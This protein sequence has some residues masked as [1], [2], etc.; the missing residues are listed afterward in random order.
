MREA[1][2]ER[3][4]RT[5]ETAQRAG[6]QEAWATTARARD[7]E[8]TVR[9]GTLEEVADSTS[10]SLSLRLF[11]D[12]R[13]STH[14]TTDL[15]PKRLAGF[16]EEA[17]AMTR[18]LQPDEFRCMP[19][20]E[21]FARGM[22]DLDLCDAAIPALDRGQRMAWC[23]AMNERCHGEPQVISVS[24]ATAD[25]HYTVAAAS[26]N[27]FRGS[28]EATSLS[29]YTEITLEEGQR[30]P[31]EVHWASARHAADLPDAAGIADEAM[32]LARARLG[33][34]KGATQRTTLVAANRCAG[35]LVGRLL[36]PAS[37]GTVQQERSFWRDRLD[38]PVL[39][40]ALHVS[41]D[42]SLPRGL[43]SRPFDREGTAAS[44]LTLIEDGCLRHYYLD[45]YY[46]KKLGRAPTTGSPSNRVV[47]PGTR[48][49]EAILADVGQ[50]I[51]VTNWLGGNMDSATGDF[52]FGVRGHRIE[53]GR[54]GGPVAEMNV[55]GN[56]L[57]L[58]ANLAE[59]GDDPWRWSAVLCPTLVFEGVQFSGT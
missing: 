33:T 55:T 47:R 59:V 39:S 44:P 48:G 35:S 8:F 32:R 16:I 56:L 26:S 36:G 14:S 6:A 22:T 37:G 40:E 54:L 38:E 17:V 24:S 7:V 53:G 18:A 34:E 9:N 19:D 4:L 31:E 49:L 57:E 1:L 43:A 42:P 20:P 27:G 29:L 10:R 3:A 50:G 11:V 15:E 21:R 41:D 25:S 52:S 28:Y 13:Y 12:G 30:R 51:Y 2:E 5:V 58:F 45:T 46:A 23:Q